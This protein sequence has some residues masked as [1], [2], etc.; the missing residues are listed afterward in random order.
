[1]LDTTK[2]LQQGQHYSDPAQRLDLVNRFNFLVGTPSKIVAPMQRN[3]VAGHMAEQD[4]EAL[5]RLYEYTINAAE[6]AQR[7]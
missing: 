5:I 3:F 7:P 4:A 6:S 2:S 1:M